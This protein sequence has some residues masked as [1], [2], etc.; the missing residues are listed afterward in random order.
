M[1]LLPSNWNGLCKNM[2]SPKLSQKEIDLGFIKV[3]HPKED[4]VV[5]MVPIEITSMIALE[6]IFELTKSEADLLR[7]KAQRLQAVRAMQY[8]W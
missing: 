3:Y 2:I 6:Q 7:E 8:E 1:E 4:R 5:Y